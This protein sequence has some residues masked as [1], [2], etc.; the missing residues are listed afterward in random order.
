MGTAYEQYIFIG[1]LHPGQLHPLVTQ[2]CRYTL[3]LSGNNEMIWSWYVDVFANVLMICR[4]SNY[5]CFLNLCS[6][7][8]S[9]DDVC[10]MMES[11]SDFSET[12]ETNC[13]R[14]V[15]QFKS[16]LYDTV[17]LTNLLFESCIYG[18]GI[19]FKESYVHFETTFQ[20]QVLSVHNS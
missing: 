5:F 18:T 4:A 9:W 11:G 19:L 16:V 6:W 10:D 15:F 14:Y 2:K 20:D 8:R 3:E 17:H 13:S 1:Q 12:Q 7:H